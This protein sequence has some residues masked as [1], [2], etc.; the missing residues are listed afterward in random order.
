MEQPELL[1]DAKFTSYDDKGH[2][3][4]HDYGK[5]FEVD[6]SRLTIAASTNQI[7]LI[8]K[9]VDTLNPPFY[10][11][12][13][14]VVSRLDNELGRY[15]S[16]LIETKEE[17]TDFMLEY[18]HFFETDGRHH[19][20]ICTLDNSGRFIYDQHN[21]IFAYGH[22]KKYIALLNREGFKEQNFSFPVPHAHAYNESNDRFEES[23]LNYWNWS[24][25]PLAN[26]DE[27]D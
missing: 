6:E 8:L 27:Y 1:S 19:L 16:P 25:F 7:A 23:I 24:I 5:I 18:K 14:L 17:L 11:L 9:L 12:Y 13:V 4:T 2:E 10:I 26:G 15:Q 21:V 22:I 3:V 20:W